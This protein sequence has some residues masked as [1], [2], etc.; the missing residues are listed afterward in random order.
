M[1]LAIILTSLQAATLATYLGGFEDGGKSFQL[2]VD[3]NSKHKK[4]QT[5]CIEAGG[6]PGKRDRLPPTDHYGRHGW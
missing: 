2:Q 4:A 6:E 1:S 5:R 3:A